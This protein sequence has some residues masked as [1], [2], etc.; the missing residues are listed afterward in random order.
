MKKKTTYILFSHSGD[1]Q[2]TNVMSRVWRGWS[3]VCKHWCRAGAAQTGWCRTSQFFMLEL[4]HCS[5]SRNRKSICKEP[6]P[7]KHHSAHRHMNDCEGI[8][9]LQTGAQESV[10]LFEPQTSSEQRD[11]DLQSYGFQS[12]HV[13]N[14]EPPESHIF[15]KEVFLPKIILNVFKISKTVFSVGKTPNYP[16]QVTL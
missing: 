10:L 1:K 2:H 6:G 8:L 16:A 12:S 7:S 9:H 5:P 4:G 3:R 11:S 13:R 15:S 14:L